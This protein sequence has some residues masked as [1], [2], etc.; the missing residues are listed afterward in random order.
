VLFRSKGIDANL[1]RL[2]NEIEERDRRDRERIAAP[3]S[4]ASGSL[5][6]D[7]SEMTIDAVID[8]VLNLIR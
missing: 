8:E 1:T 3:L 7:S 2:T 4:V 6:I 5:F